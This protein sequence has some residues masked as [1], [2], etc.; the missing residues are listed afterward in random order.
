M[1]ACVNKPHKPVRPENSHRSVEPQA[2]GLK[3]PAVNNN[4][5]DEKDEFK[6]MEEWEGTKY[7]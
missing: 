3:E 7:F 6:D 2:T 5:K 4:V 1:G